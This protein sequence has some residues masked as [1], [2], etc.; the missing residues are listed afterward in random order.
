MDVLPGIQTK[1]KQ[2]KSRLASKYHI[3]TIGLFGPVVR[4]DFDENS[5]IDILVDFSRPIGMEIMDLEMELEE[6]LQ[7]KINLISKSGIKSGYFREI[8]AEIVY[9]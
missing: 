9:V 3:K 7:R 1:L 5:L 4:N 8:Q 6:A 2:A